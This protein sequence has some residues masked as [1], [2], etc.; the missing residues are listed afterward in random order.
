M[1]P[2]MGPPRQKEEL[3]ERP[4]EETVWPECRKS[5]PKVQEEAA[6]S[7][8]R[9]LPALRAWGRCPR[10]R[11]APGP[12]PPQLDPVP[13]TDRKAQVLSA[14]PVGPPTLRALSTVAAEGCESI[15]KWKPL[16]GKRRIRLQ[17]RFS[18]QALAGARC[19]ESPAQ[20]MSQ[21]GDR[22]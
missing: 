14:P 8:A 5:A 4:C 9:P 16:E 12:S 10:Q 2:R 21:S 7:P 1:G 18:S 11:G 17:G 13:G 6:P 15:L 22:G 19:H 3:A 20:W